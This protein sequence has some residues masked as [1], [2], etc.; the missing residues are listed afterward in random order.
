MTDMQMSIICETLLLYFIQGIRRLEWN[1]GKSSALV[2]IL[3][4][5]GHLLWRQIFS[6]ISSSSQQ[7]PLLLILHSMTVWIMIRRFWYA[8]ESDDVILQLF[9]LSPI[10]AILYA[11]HVNSV[12][13]IIHFLSVPASFDANYSTL[14]YDCHFNIDS[15][16][17]IH[18]LT[19]AR[20]WFQYPNLLSLFISWK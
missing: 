20:K 9:T 17:L 7:Q 5:K 8:D 10:A 13:L 16:S 14:S 6:S 1:R 15:F 19:D 4:D 18:R 2:G 3:S 12:P 11:L